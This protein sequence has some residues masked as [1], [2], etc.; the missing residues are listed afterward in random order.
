MRKNYLNYY[1]SSAY[2]YTKDQYN[3]SPPLFSDSAPPYFSFFVLLLTASMWKKTL[4]FLEIKHF[5]DAYKS[6]I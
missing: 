4:H 5:H 6:D 3:P 1:N 2:Y